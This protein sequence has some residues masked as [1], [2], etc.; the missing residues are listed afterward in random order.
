MKRR[1]VVTGMGVVTALGC[2][3]D[4]LWTR[5]CNGESGVGP[6]ERLQVPNYRVRFGG[7]IRN[8][9]V[10]GYIEAKDVKRFDRFVQFAHVAG[11]NAVNDSGLDLSKED[12]WRCGVVLGSGIGGLE[13]IELQHARLIDK[14]PDKVSPFTIPKLIGN[15]ASAQLSIQYGLKGPNQVVVT[16]CASATNAIGDSYKLIRDGEVDVVITGGSE[17]ALT[18]IGLSAFAAMRAL[19]ERNDAPTKASRP[20][21]RD[22]DGF[23]LSEGAGLLILEEY[24]RAKARGANIYGELYGYGCSCD[25]SHITA[26][27]KDGV[28]AAYAMTQ[29]IRSAGINPED[30]GYINAHG[31]STPLGDMAETTAI[32][33]VFKEHAKKVSVSSTK[34]QLGHLLGASGGVELILSLLAIRNGV[35]PPTINY[36]TPDPECDLD[37]TPNQPRQRA[38]S[39]AMSN[40]FGFG[41]HNGSLVV[42]KPRT[43]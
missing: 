15:A 7:E 18:H 24:E 33:N 42:G 22:R 8:W 39:I 37:Y 26:P 32:K 35:I 34:S 13:T 9:S 38:I 11:V 40:S 4:E 19:S 31:T 41:G 29:A 30:I 17:A 3:V 5:I 27:D 16:A 10:D 28:G 6:L 1:V 23:V 20:F 2:K 25:G 36:E 14:G 12:P 21:D 43:P